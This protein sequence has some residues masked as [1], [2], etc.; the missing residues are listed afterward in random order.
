MS[1]DLY[2][3]RKFERVELHLKPK[4]RAAFVANQEY[5]QKIIAQ[6]P[7][8]ILDPSLIAFRRHSYFAENT[9][10]PLPLIIWVGKKPMGRM[11]S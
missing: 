6:P 7:V 8:G 5:L 3:A 9:F 1:K 10:L 11:A 4:F 2:Q